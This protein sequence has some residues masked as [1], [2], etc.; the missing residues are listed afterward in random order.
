LNVTIVSIDPAVQSLDKQL[1]DTGVALYSAAELQLGGYLGAFDVRAIANESS[2]DLAVSQAIEGAQFDLV[3]DLSQKPL[4]GQILAP[5]GYFHAPD[6]SSLEM[7]LQ[8]LPDLVGDFSKP[9]YFQYEASI[10]AHSRSELSGC[11]RCLDVCVTGAISSDGEGVSI[12]PF[13]C[14][15]C[16]SCATLCPTGAMIYA[17]PKPAEAITRTRDLISDANGVISS[18]I[19]HTEADQE[20]LE[21]LAMPENCLPLLVEEVSAFG[22]DYWA[23]MLCAGIRRIV[24]VNNASDKDPNRQALEQ[25]AT[26]LHTLLQGLGIESEVVLLSQIDSFRRCQRLHSLAISMST[27]KPAL[28]AWPAYPPAQPRLCWMARKPRRSE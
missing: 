15:G 18:L 1:T 17:Y 3:L 6:E 25:Q 23:T 13:L 16:G 12:D 14:Q 2:L 11:S 5:F 28:C 24:L 8:S 27:R 20:A 9:R 21:A 4:L 22:I 19:L 26:I 7:A 10:C